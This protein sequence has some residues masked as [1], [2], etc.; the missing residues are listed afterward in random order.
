MDRKQFL[1]TL[2]ALGAAQVCPGQDQAAGLPPKEKF[3][4]EWV[5]SLV[6]IM[7]S[8]LDERANVKLMESCGRA[9]A[10]RGALAALGKAAGGD[11]DKL[12]QAIAGNV[13]AE[14]VRR[15]G[16][17]VHL[18]YPKCYCPLVADGPAILPK[19]YCNCSR[20]WALEV[21][22]TVTGKP[23]T[24]DLLS[25]IKQGNPDCRFEIHLSA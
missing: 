21:F 18:R 9:C 20:G 13:G 14:N 19:T 15:E 2:A 7:D 12:V 4:Q 17:T 23:V 10:Q 3:K 16:N 24:V 1:G 8:Q 25:S 22:G 6:T 11:V 5:K